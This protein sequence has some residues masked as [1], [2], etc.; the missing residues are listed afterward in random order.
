MN[1]KHDSGQHMAVWQKFW[2]IVCDEWHYLIHGRPPVAIIIFAMPLAFSLL[3][4]CV[5]RGNVVNNIPFV[6]YDE[7]QSK[8]SRSLIQAYADADR[9]TYVAQAASEEEM[10]EAIESG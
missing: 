10:Q 8:L 2:A 9:F 4:G 5:Y 7:N 6:V 1:G 3:F